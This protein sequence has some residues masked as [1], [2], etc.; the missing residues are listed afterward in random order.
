[1][2]FTTKKLKDYEVELTVDLGKE[3]LLKY[4]A[5]AEKKLAGQLEVEGFRPGKA[6]KEMVRKQIGEQAIRE[7]ALNL[8]IQTSLVKVLAEEELEIIEQT[9]LKIKENSADKLIYQV[10]FLVFPEVQLGEYK[11]LTVKRNSA[12]V[13]EDEVKTILQDIVSSRTALKEVNRAAQTGDRVE[14]DFT[15]KD[16][17]TVI[18]GG[19]SENHPVVLGENKFVPGF[20]AQIIGMKT[21]EKKN[22]SL[23]MP[24]DYFQKQIAG[25]ELDFEVALKCV[26]E[27]I[28]PQLGDDFVKTLGNFQ[29]L[30]ELEGN[31]KQG[32]VLE[33]ETKE[34]ER[35]RLAVLK[36]AADKTKVEIPASLVEKRLDSMIQGLDKELHEKGMELGP[37]LAHVKKPQ[38][39]LRREWR[40]KA[41]E[42]VKL[43]LVARAIAKKEHLK[44]SDKEVDE[45]FQAVLQQYMLRGQAEGGPTGP[46]VLQNINPDDLRSKIH[47]VLLNEKIFEFLEKNTKFT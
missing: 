30:A 5:E 11:G 45:E 28:A 39:D 24:A 13:G 29:S 15:V 34:K 25:K 8:A 27:R 35:I 43:S 47:E 23:K 12:S 6:P 36:E 1:M 41:E 3:E 20:E 18:D 2:T 26:E 40:T 46:E 44:V 37:Y 42:Q 22:F 17:G 32:L 9:D 7:E 19:K 14:V 4:S 33:K 10:K 38:D 16:Q 31:I 21:G